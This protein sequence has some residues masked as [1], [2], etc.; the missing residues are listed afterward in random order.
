LPVYEFEC[1]G[2]SSHFELIRSFSDDGTVSCPECGCDAQ[3]I[4]SPV[5]VIFKGSGFYV[6]DHRNNRSQPQSTINSAQSSESKPEPAG[7]SASAD[8]TD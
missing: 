3:R 8:K 1:T 4:F 6:T 7:N 2:C 5:P